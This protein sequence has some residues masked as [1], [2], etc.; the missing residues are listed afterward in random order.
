MKKT[1]IILLIIF[2]LF[3]SGCGYGK[4]EGKIIDK[5]HQERKTILQPRYTG[6]GWMMMPVVYPEKWS[7]KLKKQESRRNKNNL[8]NSNRRIL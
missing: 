5:E 6:K 8:G 4:L 7:V 1:A 3:L 2:A